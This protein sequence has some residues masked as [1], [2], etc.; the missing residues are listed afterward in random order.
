VRTILLVAEQREGKVREITFEML[1]KAKEL[2][3][4]ID[5]QISV[6]LL[7]YDVDNLTKELSIVGVDEI[8]LFE[9]EKL[10]IYNCDGYQIVLSELVKEKKPILTMIGHTSL[11]VD[12]SP[13]L[14]TKLNLPLVTDC[15]DLRFSND[16][17]TATRQMHSDKASV[18][19]IFPH[20]TQ[21][22]V[23]VRP[24]A[25]SPLKEPS[26]NSVK[27]VRVSSCLKDKHLRSEV[28]EIVKPFDE[29]VDITKANIIV[30]VG[31]AF[32]T[33]E[34]LVVAKN[35]CEAVGGVLAASR[36]ITDKG[37]LSEA[38]QVGLTGKIV[39]PKLYIALGISGQTQHV[40]GMKNSKMIVAI[41]KDP[42]APIFSV[43]DYGIVANLFDVVPI[44]DEQIKSAQE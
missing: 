24:T 25:F 8:L 9:D 22:I 39:K 14:A 44:L 17:L 12:F 33:E 23:T 11:G 36:P 32:K 16:K 7:G 18:E 38:R 41:N 40:A 30:A 6:V 43:A 4:E 34:D 29:D 31:R 1:A 35:L 27:I 20:S 5:A 10:K 2:A 21:Y 13:G 15:T 42:T 3:E 28:I 37:W 19:I 26:S